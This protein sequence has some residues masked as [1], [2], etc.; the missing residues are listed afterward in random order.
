MLRS[1]LQIDELDYERRMAGYSRLV[2]DTWQAMTARQA[3][4]LL[5]TCLHDLRNAGA[6]PGGV[7]QGR[8]LGATHQAACCRLHARSRSLLPFTTPLHTLPCLLSPMQTTSRCA[9]L[10]ARRSPALSRGLRPR[11]PRRSRPPA[12]PTPCYRLRSECSS[13]SSSAGCRRPTWLCGMRVGQRGAY[14][15]SA[16]RGRLR[17]E[18][19]RLCMPG[20]VNAWQAVG[21]LGF[22]GAG[23]GRHK[24]VHPCPPTPPMC[25]QEHLSLLRQ[26]VLAFPAQ[27]P[28]LTALTGAWCLCV[29]VCGGVGGWVWGGGR[30]CVAAW[31]WQHVQG[32]R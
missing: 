23:D 30:S 6:L 24:A 20:S 28:D 21:S 3:A 1:A 19:G 7:P 27:Y 8:S 4:P 26:L 31:G 15:H 25:L 18:A 32:Q 9:T 12:A 17:S 14:G 11:P 13:H 2:P 22:K 16:E 5:H 29:V 10:P